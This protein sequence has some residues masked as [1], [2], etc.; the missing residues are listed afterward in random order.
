MGVDVWRSGGEGLA[1]QGALAWPLRRNAPRERRYLL[2]LSHMRS[3]SSLLAHVLGSSPEVDGYGET[4][5]RYQL[6]LDLWR[7]RRQVRRSTGQPLRGTW[8]LDKVLHN[9]IKPLDRWV[10][11]ERLR[12][13]I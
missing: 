9:R 8:L 4:L 11:P 3:Y 1:P 13:L 5:L 2:L 6:P 12:A 10:E 7:L